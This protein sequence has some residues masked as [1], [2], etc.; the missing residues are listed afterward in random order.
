M[1][2]GY[3]VIMVISTV[4]NMVMTKSLHFTHYVAWIATLLWTGI[5]NYFILK[6]IWSFG[7]KGPESADEKA[8]GR[9]SF[10]LNNATNDDVI[11]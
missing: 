1:Y 9:K 4:F 7:G 8:R 2:G 11:V 6:H 10:E 5:V 3:S